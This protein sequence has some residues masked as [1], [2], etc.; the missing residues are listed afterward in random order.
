MAH[1]VWEY[2]HTTNNGQNPELHKIKAEVYETWGGINRAFE[3]IISA[4]NKLQKA[5]GDNG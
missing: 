4:L 3:Q 5:R 1:S 2:S